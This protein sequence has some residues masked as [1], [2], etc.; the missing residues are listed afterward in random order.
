MMRLRNVEM[1]FVLLLAPA[2]WAAEPNQATSPEKVVESIPVAIFDFESKAPGNPDLGQQLG[3][4]LTARLSTY[5][6]FTLVERKRLQDV[7]AEM[8]LNLSGMVETGQATKVGKV[9]GA[10]I[11]VFGRAFAVDRDLYLVA[12]IVGA[13]TSQVKG[14]LARGKLESDLSATIDQLVEKLV[15]GLD[16]WGPQLLPRTEKLESKIDKLRARLKG[17]DLP[18]V[19]VI[20]PESHARSRLPDPAAAAEIKKVFK[21][22]GFEVVEGDR[23]TLEK[24]TKNVSLAGSDIVI[25]GEGLSDFGAQLGGLTSCVARL[26]VQAVWRDSARVIAAER[27]TRRAVDLSEAIAAKTA[28]QSAGHELAIALITKIAE[29]TTPPAESDQ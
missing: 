13:E 29:A 6:Q 3:D 9:V 21:D 8:Q 2:L 14:V 7:L 16:Q 23:Q 27:T 12:K 18:S 22:V 15:G 5:D 17:K 10:R 11:L 19:V 20:V 24:W 4:I 26:E 1:T 28:L 25:T